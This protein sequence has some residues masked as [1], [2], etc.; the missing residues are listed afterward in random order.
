M[1]VRTQSAPSTASLASK[2]TVTWPP[3]L[4]AHSIFSWLTT[5]A[6]GVAIRNSNPSLTEA[7]NQEAA[8]LFPSPTQATILP[9]MDPRCSSK[10]RISA[11]IWHGWDSSVRPLITGIEENVAKSNNFWWASVRSIMILA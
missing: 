6:G 9:S 11:I 7:C 8:T 5:N 3:S 1:S 4:F 10:V 2:H